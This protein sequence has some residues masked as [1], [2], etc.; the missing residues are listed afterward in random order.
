MACINREP[1]GRKTIQFVGSDG[2]RHS[3]RLGKASQKTAESAKVRVEALLGAKL[4]GLPIDQDTA[5]WVAQQVDPIL[6]RRLAAAGLL[7]ETIILDDQQRDES[8][9]A[10]FLRS[11]IDGRGRIKPNTKRNFDQS[12]KYLTRHFGPSR[13]LADISAGD[14]D[15]WREAMLADGLSEATISREV[16]RARQFFR[17]AMRRKLIAENPFVDLPSPAQ[18]NE[19]RQFFVSRDMADAV[20]QACPD[21]EWR[22]IFAL[23]RYGGLRMPSEALALTWSDIDWERERMTIRSPKTAHHKSGGVRQVPIFPELRPHLDAVWFEPDRE[24][25]FV[26]SRY[27]DANQNMRTQLNRIIRRAGLE[28]WPKTFQ[29]CRSTRETELAADYP[30]H[31]VVAW[32]GNSAAVAQAHYLQVTDADFERGARGAEKSGAESGAVKSDSWGKHPV[33]N[34]GQHS[35][36]RV[37]VDGQ[38]TQKAR[39]K[40]SFSPLP[41]S[42]F[43]F[44]QLVGIPPRG[45]EPLFSD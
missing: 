36:A 29:N 9:L 41:A 37:C 31:V 12:F 11:Y 25:Q 16:K 35:A 5:T 26:I 7:P 23:A 32:I 6:R 2:K 8:T 3:V 38:E 20:L 1:N 39:G 30:L 22:L 33:Q 14:A 4:T 34:A 13:R 24:G 28:P 44:L 27:R 42:S 43:D 45:V 19:T 15:Q 10:G 17:A 18:V 21:N 40:P